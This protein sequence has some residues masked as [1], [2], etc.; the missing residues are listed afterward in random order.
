MTPNAMRAKGF[1]LTAGARDEEHIA[2]LPRLYEQAALQILAAVR[3]ANL[4]MNLPEIKVSE[5][6]DWLPD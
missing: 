1:P 3:Y 5:L 2:T 4:V 6:S